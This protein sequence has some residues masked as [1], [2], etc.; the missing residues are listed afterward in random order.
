MKT[1]QVIGAVLMGLLLVTAG[2][3]GLTGGDGGAGDGGSGAGGEVDASYA[4]EAGESYVYTANGSDSS[5][6]FDVESV[7]DGDVTVNISTESGQRTTVTASQAEI[8]NESR[9]AS[10]TGAVF[11]TFLRIPVLAADG[12]TLETGNTWTVGSDQLAMGQSQDTEELTVEVTGTDTVAGQECYT[13][14]ISS[15]SQNGTISSCVRADWPFALSIS[16]TGGSGD[17]ELDIAVDEFE[18]P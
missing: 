15:E 9:Q 8:F 7:E 5:V 4:F 11:V 16:N 18:R 14:E 13:T 6:R 3:N 2:C 12:Q 1:R 10:M 17:V